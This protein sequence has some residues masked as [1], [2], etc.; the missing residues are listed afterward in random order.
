M[1]ESST[2]A[3][4]PP[5]TGNRT[6]VWVVIVLAIVAAALI[7]WKC[8]S[9]DPPPPPPPPEK[10]AL[11]PPPPPPPPPPP[12]EDAGPDAAPEPPK[13]PIVKRTG[14]KGCKPKC[15]GN[16]TPALN[17]ALAIRARGAKSCY[18]KALR[19]NST[20]AGKM[21]VSI[22]VAPSGALCSSRVSTNE[23]RDASVASCVRR[24]LVSKALPK[25]D[26]GCVDVKVPLNF[27]PN[28]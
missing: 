11:K 2:P 17:Q 8:S 10:P 16:V 18:E 19:T 20:L 28:Q 13:K 6:F 9:S 1:A 5:G 26:G 21:V 7:I 12:E 24:R 14:P 4:P 27:K 25:P 23:L 15:A 3:T 22:K